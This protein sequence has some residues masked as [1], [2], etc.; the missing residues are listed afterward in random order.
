MSNLVS[1]IKHPAAPLTRERHVSCMVTKAEQSSERQQAGGGGEI[2]GFVIWQG[3]H[4]PSLPRNL[5]PWN[6]RGKGAFCLPLG[7]F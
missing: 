2:C 4:Q 7:L 1:H 5:P 6:N 3:N